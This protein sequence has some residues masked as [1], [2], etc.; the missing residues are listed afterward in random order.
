MSV[1]ISQ[2]KSNH[3]NFGAKEIYA[4]RGH[5]EPYM[6]LDNKVDGFKVLFPEG[7]PQIVLINKYSEPLG[8]YKSE[9]W[10]TERMVENVLNGNNDILGKKIDFES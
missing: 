4:H 9:D 5:I 7:F 1:S 2:C 8:I 6:P 10:Q 3:I